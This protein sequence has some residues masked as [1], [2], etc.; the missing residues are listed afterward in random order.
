[1]YAIL[2]FLGACLFIGTVTVVS[3]KLGE[4]KTENPKMAALT[5]FLLAFLPPL[6]LIYLAVLVF[7][8]DVSV[9]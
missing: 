7:K 9:V 4:R 3:Y 1:M 8:E 2:M 6:A 5:G